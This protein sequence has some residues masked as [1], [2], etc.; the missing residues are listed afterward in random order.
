MKT[1]LLRAF[2]IGGSLAL[3]ACADLSVKKDSYETTEI[4]RQ[5]GRAEPADHYEGTASWGG[6]NPK[7]IDP[8]ELDRAKANAK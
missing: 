8:S 4:D 6:S 7:D 5:T 1:W 3:A 2:I